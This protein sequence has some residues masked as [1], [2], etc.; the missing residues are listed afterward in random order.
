M[1]LENADI[2]EIEEGLDRSARGKWVKPNER[3]DG[4]MDGFAE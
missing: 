2:D 3:M 1:L 4:W